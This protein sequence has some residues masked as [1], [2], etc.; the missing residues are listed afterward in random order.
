MVLTIFDIAI[1]E[2]YSRSYQRVNDEWVLDKAE[3]LET[4]VFVTD[5]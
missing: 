4:E 5:F 3:K 2:D 1:T